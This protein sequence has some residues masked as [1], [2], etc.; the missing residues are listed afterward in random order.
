MAPRYRWRYFR[1][2][3]DCGFV[4]VFAKVLAFGP[5]IDCVFCS[6]GPFWT[7]D[8]EVN[9]RAFLFGR[10]DDSVRWMA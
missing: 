7:P 4:C 10:K 9:F 8:F 3:V 1:C 6:F 5:E 2:G